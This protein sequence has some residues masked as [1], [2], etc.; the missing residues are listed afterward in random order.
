MS[1]AAVCKLHPGREGDLVN[2]IVVNW[3]K[4]PFNLGPWIHWDTD[5]NDEAGYRLLNE[6][7]GRVYFS[8][9]HLSQLPSWQEGGV[10][11]AR[12]T[13]AEIGRRNVSQTLME[14]DET[15]GYG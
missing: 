7:D 10:L 13:V 4:V 15:L 2:P 1:R 5:G 12:R 11:A 14:D 3:A 6:P 9:A 8:G